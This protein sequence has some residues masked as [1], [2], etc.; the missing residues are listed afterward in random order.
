VSNDIVID[1]QDRLAGLSNL[2]GEMR[3]GKW[4]NEWLELELSRCADP[5]WNANFKKHFGL[6]R[7][8]PDDFG[9]RLLTFG[10]MK[11][12]GGI[13]FYGGNTSLPFVNILAWSGPVGWAEL[14]EIA[15]SEWSC[16]APP[17]LRVLV[18]ALPHH[19]GAII[20]QTV[21][22]AQLEAVAQ[23]EPRLS[24]LNCDDPQEAAAI[25]ERWY[26]EL[27]SDQPH[28]ATEVLPADS[29]DLAECLDQGSLDW[30]MID[31]ALAGVVG[32]AP[33]EIDY[34]HGHVVVEEV[35]ARAYRGKGFGHSIQKALARRLLESKANDELLIGTI[36]RLNHASRRTAE[37]A[38]RQAILRYCFLP[39]R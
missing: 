12:L 5:A 29:E 19:P 23:G 26:A 24:L 7:V 39:L 16:F 22:A 1:T 32:T 15:K 18:D 31:G 38:G 13:R 27:A 11:V 2:A 28:L 3:L 6:P 33:G 25:V 35:L 14:I 36:H 34:L 8:T 30:V 9:N 37:N 10:D 21:H 4:V 17:R 20:D